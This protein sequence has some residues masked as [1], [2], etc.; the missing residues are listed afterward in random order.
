MDDICMTPY[1][2]PVELNR[3]LTDT[4]GSHRLLRETIYA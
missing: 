3:Y 2:I 4:S 1:E